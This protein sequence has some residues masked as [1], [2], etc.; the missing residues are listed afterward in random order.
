MQSQP[1]ERIPLMGGGDSLPAGSRVPHGGGGGRARG[2]GLLKGNLRIMPTS[3][4][5][6][7]LGVCGL[8]IT[9]QTAAAYLLG[10]PSIKDLADVISLV[11]FNIGTTLLLL[12]VLKLLIAPA[13]FLSDVKSLDGSTD[14]SCLSMATMMIA[15]WLRV[16]GFWDLGWNLWQ[17]AVTA[18]CTLLLA[19]LRHTWPFSWQRVTPGWLT[20]LTGLATAAGTGSALGAGQWVDWFFWASFLGFLLG[21][22][23]SDNRHCASLCALMCMFGCTECQHSPF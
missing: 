2:L 3:V 12:F 6:L 21:V 5:G 11:S 13:D 8:G 23:C 22:W 17:A 18:H 16:H 1:H 20:P 14:L 9:W 19:F 7:A 15:W 10:A 4:A